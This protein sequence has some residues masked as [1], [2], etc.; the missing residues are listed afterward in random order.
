MR[1]TA[2][3][4]SLIAAIG[5]TASANGQAFTVTGSCSPPVSCDHVTV[6]QQQDGSTVLQFSEQT[7]QGT[8]YVSYVGS[9]ENLSVISISQVF[10]Q[11]QLTKRPKG[12]SHCVFGYDAAGS[13][14]SISCPGLTT[15]SAAQGSN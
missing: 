7:E 15:F 2:V 9:P 6:A 4:L 3:L 11:G 12:H 10:V 13:I 8:N 14:S 5:L 1:K